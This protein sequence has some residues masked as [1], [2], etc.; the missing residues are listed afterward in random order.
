MVFE[1]DCSVDSVEIDCLVE[2][3]FSSIVVS[4]VVSPFNGLHTPVPSGALHVVPK[5]HHILSP[6]AL[7][8]RHGK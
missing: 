6:F 7:T 8:R 1:V 3:G 5:W 4:A 2:V